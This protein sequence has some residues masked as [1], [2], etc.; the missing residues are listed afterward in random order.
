MKAARLD[1]EA[2]KELREATAWYKERSPDVARRF[3]ETIRELTR[4]IARRPLQFP[5]LSDP[6]LEPSVRR[7]LVPGFP[8]ALVFVVVGASV[9]IVAVAHQHRV[10]GYWLYRIRDEQR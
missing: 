9:Q 8:Y 5:Q 3:V 4:T 2:L 10:P 6:K 7:A 1:P